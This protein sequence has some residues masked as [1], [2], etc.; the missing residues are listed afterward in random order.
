[1]QYMRAHG[2]TPGPTHRP[3]LTGAISG[4]LAGVLALAIKYVSTALASEAANFGFTLW[5]AVAIDITFFVLS[6]VIYAA[7]FRRAAN[8][9]SGGWLF[10]SSFGFLIWMLGPVAIW[11]LTTGT[12]LAAGRSAIGLFVAQILYGTALGGIYPYI[13]QA[14]QSRMR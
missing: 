1:M 5:T 8:D 14:V 13:H 7:I 11:Q 4:A 10:G 12:Q 9:H 6:G 2:N 3:Y